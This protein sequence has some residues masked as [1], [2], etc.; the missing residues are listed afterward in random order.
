MKRFKKAL[1]VAGLTLLI[2]LALSGIGITG[3]FFTG[4]KEQFMDNEIKTEQVDK[5]EDEDEMNKT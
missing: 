4:K 3:T 5:K 1:R 2:L